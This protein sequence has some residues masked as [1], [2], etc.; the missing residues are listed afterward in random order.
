M[1]V[2]FVLV[3]LFSA[4]NAGTADSTSLTAAAD[5]ADSTWAVADDFGQHYEIHFD[6]AGTITSQ[7]V[8]SRLIEQKGDLERPFRKTKLKLEI[9][10][11]GKWTQK[12]SNVEFTLN[13][14]AGSKM[15]EV[16][17]PHYIYTGT[18]AGSRITGY[19]KSEFW[20]IH[21]WAAMPVKELSN[22][23]DGPPLLLI[24]GT[25]EFPLK[26]REENGS[27]TIRLKISSAGD[28]VEASVMEA[29]PAKSL[30][31]PP[32][33]RCRNGNLFPR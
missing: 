31:S 23:R 25:V 29:S 16:Q 27:A 14:A 28:V 10:T 8:T 30:V 20:G 33:N 32:K 5:V 22:R 2:L 4:A 6:K 15:A 17:N 19:M 7:R 1:K 24:G 26:S 11:G 13:E 3:I 12:N 9:V 21:H 18:I